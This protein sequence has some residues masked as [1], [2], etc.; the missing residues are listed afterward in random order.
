MNRKKPDT[1][2]FYR[3][4]MQATNAAGHAHFNNEASEEVQV[5]IRPDKLISPG[6]FKPDPLIPGNFKAHPITIA[7]MRKD[8]F[9]G[10]EDVHIDLEKTYS[11]NGC[12]KQLDIQFWLFCPFCEAPFPKDLETL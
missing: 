1:E 9:V 3:K 7:A 11:C 8:I 5:G 2:D 4:L 12:Q 6:M 10:G